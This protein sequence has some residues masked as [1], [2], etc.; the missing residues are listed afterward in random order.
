MPCQQLPGGRL[1]ALRIAWGW[2][3]V[4]A[5][6]LT[7]NTRGPLAA[8]SMRP[9]A[10][11]SAAMTA[12]GSAA[13]V[14]V[15]RWQPQRRGAPR[16]GAAAHRPG[17]HAGLRWPPP[18]LEHSLSYLAT[19]L[20]HL[21]KHLHASGPCCHLWPALLPSQPL[22]LSLSCTPQVGDESDAKKLLRRAAEHYGVPTT[23]A[24]AVDSVKHWS[25][26]V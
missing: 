25:G 19:Q 12:V 3:P 13:S 16:G 26:S 17:W 14:Q 4:L 23:M 24:G 1:P 10:L 21:H 8:S 11:D 2:W 22:C 18:P 6:T 15:D 9:E 7:G 5:L 20:W